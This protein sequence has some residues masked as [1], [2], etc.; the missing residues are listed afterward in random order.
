MSLPARL[1][2]A[3]IALY[4]LVSPLLGPR[5][6]FLPGCSDYAAEALLRHGVWRGG[7][8]AVRRICRCHPLTALGGGSGF[9]PVPETVIRD[10]SHTLPAASPSHGR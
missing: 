1:C 6:R 10:T 5:C 4:R 8:L 2:L 3:L 7:G 9:D